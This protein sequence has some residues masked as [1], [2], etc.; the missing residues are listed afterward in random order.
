[1]KN[2]RR[3]ICCFKIILRNTLSNI[4]I[5][6]YNPIMANQRKK[7]EILWHLKHLFFPLKSVLI[8]EYSRIIIKTVLSRIRYDLIPWYINMAIQVDLWWRCNIYYTFQNHPYFK[9]HSISIP[10]NW[11]N[12]YQIT[13]L[14]YLCRLN[15]WI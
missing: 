2:K 7:G 11:P 4:Q 12:I 1:M 6:F 13:K 3:L 8:I 15:C 9:D 5:P 14:C 10:R